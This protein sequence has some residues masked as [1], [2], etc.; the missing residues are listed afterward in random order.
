MWKLSIVEYDNFIDPNTGKS[1]AEEVEI[2]EMNSVEELADFLLN[3]KKDY[4]KNP[5]F[6]CRACG[7]WTSYQLILEDKSQ[8]IVSI[9]NIFELFLDNREL[10][11]DKANISLKQI[12]K[13]LANGIT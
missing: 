1:R 8:S 6:F 2:F 12:E 13:I 7:F 9:R 10:V 3:I 11:W 5:E 4:N